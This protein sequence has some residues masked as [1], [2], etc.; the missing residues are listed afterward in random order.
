[1]SQTAMMVLIFI[2]AVMSYKVHASLQVTSQYSLMQYTRIISEEHFS[3][4]RPLV[5]VLPIA[6]KESTSEEV[7]YLIKALH[8]L[9]RWPILVYNVGNNINGNMYTDINKH[10]AYIIPILGPCEDWTE[11]ISRFQQQVY[12]LSADNN[13]WHSWNPR[14]KFIVA[15]MSNCERKENT[16]ISRAILSELWLNEVME[17]AVLFLV[18]NE[19]EISDLER[20]TNDSVYGTY[21]EM[22]S[23]FPYENSERCHP[24]EGTVPVKVFKARNFSE[25]KKIDIFQKDNKKNFHKCPITVH[26]YTEPPFVNWPKTVWNK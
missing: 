5:I 10:E 3:P 18:S 4:G 20:N 17:T 19:H 24:T 16:E 22:H 25:I 1:M 14:A 2:L 7:G 21:L 11:Y 23:C 13:T 6:V 9:G 12:E 8:I 15:V 26:A